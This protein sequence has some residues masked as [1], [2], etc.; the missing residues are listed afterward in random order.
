MAGETQYARAFEL[1]ADE[2]RDLSEPLGEIGDLIL[3]SVSE[4]FRSEGSHGG[5]RW[6]SLNPDYERWKR[7]QVGDEPILVFHGTMRAAMLAHSAIH[8]TPRRLVYD[9][10]APEYALRHQ[11]GDEGRNLPQRRM[12]ELPAADRREWDHVF[13]R[14]I[15][16][17]RRGR[18]A[19]LRI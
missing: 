11:K 13:A 7:Q 15:N 5:S 16:S 4:Q 2:A 19:G 6:H 3:Q 1:A 12:V 14:W 10:Q 8:V 18:L 9:P 17:I